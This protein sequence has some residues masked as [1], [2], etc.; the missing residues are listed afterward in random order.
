[1][2]SRNA[3]IIHA[4][5]RGLQKCTTDSLFPSITPG[6]YPPS[7]GSLYGAEV[8]CHLTDSTHK[9]LKEHVM[10]EQLLP[11]ADLHIKKIAQR[12]CPE[13]QRLNSYGVGV[14]VPL[15]VVLAT[16]SNVPL[17]QPL[18]A[19]TPVMMPSAI[20]TARRAYSTDSSPSSSFTNLTKRFIL[21]PPFF[22]DSQ[23]RSLRLLILFKSNGCAKRRKKRKKCRVYFL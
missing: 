17:I 23:A 3:V 6:G 20:K 16:F 5:P 18:S 8:W 4:H 14:G 10:K 2:A 21:T 11:G 19:D 15:G 9:T 7:F 22:L 1:M 13:P 12:G